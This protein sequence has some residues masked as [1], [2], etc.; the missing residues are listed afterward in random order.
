MPELTNILLSIIIAL[1]SWI[2][3]KGYDKID[4][5]FSMIRT[6][7]IKSERVDTEM[8]QMKDDINDHEVRLRDIESD[9]EVRN[10]LN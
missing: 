10:K 8:K 4:Q 6:L 3:V 1:I 9:S 7:L 2:G 5:L